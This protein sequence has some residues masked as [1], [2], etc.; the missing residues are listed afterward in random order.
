MTEHEGISSLGDQG[1][2][3]AAWKRCRG[4]EKSAEDL[5]GPP[6]RMESERRSTAAVLGT[7]PLNKKK[8]IVTTRYTKIPRDCVCSP[9]GPSQLASQTTCVFVCATYYATTSVHARHALP[10][11]IKPPET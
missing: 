10:K 8:F 1:R 9:L 7:L 2:P 4:T 5:V 3:G 11:L 6:E